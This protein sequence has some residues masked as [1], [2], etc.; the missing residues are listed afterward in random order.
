MDFQLSPEQRD[1]QDLV[2]A[3]QEKL[4]PLAPRWD[5]T[6]AFPWESIHALA[7]AGLL[8]PL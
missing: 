4:K 8:G 1:L 5:R 6:H 7:G 3:I 2:R